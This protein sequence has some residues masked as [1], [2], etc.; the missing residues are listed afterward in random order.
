[1]DTVLTFH[2]N[3]AHNLTRPPFE[4]IQDAPLEQGER[5]AV[6]RQRRDRVVARHARARRAR[7]ARRGAP[8]RR[9]HAAAVLQFRAREGFGKVQPG[10]MDRR[11]ARLEEQRQVEEVGASEGALLPRPRE[12]GG[13]AARSD[14]GVCCAVEARRPGRA[15]G[16]R[17]RGLC[18][19][20][21]A[22][23]VARSRS[24]SRVR[25][26]VRVR[27]RVVAVLFLLAC[28][29][30][31]SLLLTP[32]CVALSTPSHAQ[33]ASTSSSTSPCRS[34]SIR[35]RTVCTVTFYVPF[36]FMRFLL[37]I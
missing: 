21:R 14:E 32:P 22:R 18:V 1:M 37:T 7:H 6:V 4:H 11:G 35:S 3:L 15:L 26:R 33:T 19:C 23:A 34:T 10:G 9:R 20:V 12:H 13:G 29:R 31:L 2:A 24:R 17:H 27:G 30:L 25:V 28:A 16:A 36:Y 5:S 8:Q